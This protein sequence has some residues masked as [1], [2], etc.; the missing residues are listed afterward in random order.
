MNILIIEDNE[1]KYKQ[2]C[3]SLKRVLKEPNIVWA[4]SRNSGLMSFMLENKKLRKNPYHL[5][6]TDNYLPL[7]S[8][9]EG[10]IFDNEAEVF[11]FAMDIISEIRR[12][13]F[14]RLPIIVCSSDDFE[15]CD[16]CFNIKYDSSVLLDKK[17]QDIFDYLDE[18]VESFHITFESLSQ[19]I[20]RVK[21]CRTCQNMS[22]RVE[23]CEKPIENCNAYIYHEKE[24]ILKKENK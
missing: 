1:C 23:T 7:Y 22:C 14:E 2:I 11:P 19:D 5:V 24:V 9:N 6:I 17:F 12:L 4:D 13:G 20:K 15:D 10:D 21:D 3:E 18:Y 16:F 8:V